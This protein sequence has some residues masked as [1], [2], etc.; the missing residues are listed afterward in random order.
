MK[1]YTSPFSSN[2]RKP[3]MLA[4]LLPLQ[5]ELIVVDLAQGE[6]RR[7]PY[8]GFNPNG[9]VPTLVDGD[10]VLWESNAIMQYMA[11]QVPG[12]PLYPQA[13]R[14]RADVNRWLFWAATH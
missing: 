7:P 10:F 4:H 14:R 13:P 5:V 1:L 8:L 12:T 9:K 3:A 2:A 11:E 6:Q